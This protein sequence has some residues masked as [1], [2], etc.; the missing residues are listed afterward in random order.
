[1][2]KSVYS[3]VLMD[4]VVEAVDRLAASLGTSRSNLINQILAEK[5]SCETPQRRMQDVFG[6]LEKFLGNEDCF[7]PMINA[8]DAMY[9]I[10]TALRYKYNPS[11]RYLVE[12]SHQPGRVGELRV[13]FRTKSQS[14]LDIIDSFFSFWAEMENSAVG[15][16]FPNGIMAYQSEGRYIRELNFPANASTINSERLGYAIGEYITILDEV[17]KTYISNLDGN[18]RS[19]AYQKYITYPRK[20]SYI[21]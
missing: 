15:G 9:S 4:D 10:K 8:S 16:L 21:L 6:Y 14:F 13:S 7:Q 5:V 3:L 1:M 20:S 18:C 17:L 11:V 12:L 19:A 2:K